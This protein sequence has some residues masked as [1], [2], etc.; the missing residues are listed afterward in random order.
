MTTDDQTVGGEHQL[1]GQ[2]VHDNVEAEVPDLLQL[3]SGPRQA[4][5][6]ESRHQPPTEVVSEAG[7]R[8][9]GRHVKAGQGDD[10]E[11]RLHH[12]QR[13]GEPCHRYRDADGIHQIVALQA[14]QHP[15]KGIGEPRQAHVHRRQEDDGLD[16]RDQRFL[17][18]DERHAPLRRAD[19]DQQ[20]DESHDHVEVDR[21]AD[22]GVDGVLITARLV[23]RDVPDD[24][25]PDSEV[26]EPQV[27]RELH[28]D[29]PD[30]IPGV[31]QA[32]DDDRGKNE[33]EP[34]A[35]GQA[36]PVR[37]DIADYRGR[38]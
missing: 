38:R 20:R 13:P 33:G 35:D 30:A 3:A 18:L 29:S 24:G 16:G 26:E 12:Q 10:S 23:P 21:N 15:D 9:R 32:P 4:D 5:D 25:I 2:V 7:L 8:A 1:R 37:E 27:S 17:D 36:A 34:D 19:A 6:V 11:A 28:R 14:D 22:L 31:S